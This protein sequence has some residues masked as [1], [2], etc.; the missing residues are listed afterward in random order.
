M[1]KEDLAYC[2]GLYEGE[3]TV[4]TNLI[5]GKYRYINLAIVM[6]DLEPLYLFADTVNVGRLNGPYNLNYKDGLIR[7]ERYRYY[8]SGFEKV[9]YIIAMI[10]PWLSPRRKEQYERAVIRCLTGAGESMGQVEKRRKGDALD[11]VTDGTTWP[12]QM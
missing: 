3:G 5:K 1:N 2:A 12:G 11:Y 6:S 8:A 9:Q 7:K 10:W 4:Y